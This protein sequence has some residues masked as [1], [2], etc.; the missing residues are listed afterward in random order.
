M[1]V[2]S[3][4]CTLFQ[5]AAPLPTIPPCLRASAARMSVGIWIEWGFW[6]PAAVR[7]FDAMP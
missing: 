3:S 5:T 6:T 4:M 2:P 7:T 1:D